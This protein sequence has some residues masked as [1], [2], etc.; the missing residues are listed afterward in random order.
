VE[1]NIN[2]FFMGTLTGQ[3]INNTYDG[4][5]KLEDSTTGITSTYQQIQDGLGNDTNTRIST[6][7]I[8]S[9]NIVN[10]NNLKPDYCGNGFTSV[11]VAPVANTQNRV[12]YLPFYDSGNYSFSAISYNL[13][14]LSSTS[15]VVSVAF[16]T[17]QQVPLVG[18]APKD[19]I[20]SGITFDSVAPATTGVKT[21]LLPSTLSFSGTGG[22]FYIIAFNITNG[23]V[24]PTVRYGQPILSIA[25]QS[26]AYNLGLYLNVAGTATQVGQRFPSFGGQ[27]SVL[28]NLQFQTSYSESDISTNSSTTVG[29]PAFGFGLKPI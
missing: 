25:N 22:G 17:M 5:L 29:G 27:T 11:G 4:L 23:G 18:I 13:T 8:L 10:M 3:Q 24:T 1:Y 2:N 9:P 16:Y 19:L 26:Y 7:G 12:L 20:M 14:T 21:S 15:D 6:S 28:N